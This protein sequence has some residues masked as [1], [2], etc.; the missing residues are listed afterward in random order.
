MSEYQRSRR[1]MRRPD[2]P[3]DEGLHECPFCKVEVEPHHNYCWSCGKALKG[4][5]IKVCKS[6]GKPFKTTKPEARNRCN[7]CENPKGDSILGRLR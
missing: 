6:C 5:F 7:K 3:K 2:E 4:V 1:G